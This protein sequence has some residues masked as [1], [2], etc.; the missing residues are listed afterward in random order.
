MDV[1]A[2]LATFVRVADAGSFSAVAR[3]RNTTQP[4]VSRQITALEDHLGARLLQRTTRSLA[5]TPEGRELLE[6]ARRV[7]ADVAEAEA[8]VGSR[9]TSPTGLVRLGATVAMGRMMI[10]P[11]LGTLLT[12][13]PGLEIELS[14]SD[15]IADLVQ[16]GLDFAI[17]V[18]QVTDAGLIARRIGVVETVLVASRD[19]L[20]RHPAPATPAELAGHECLVYLARNAVEWRFERGGGSETVKVTGRFRTDSVDAVRAAVLAS[21]GVGRLPSWFFTRELREGTVQRV[22]PGWRTPRLPIQAVYPSRR[23]LAP[24]TRAVI[25]FLAGEFRLDPLVSDYGLG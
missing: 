11:R 22:L 25:E 24:R 7:L 16:E 23:F 2:A 6:H 10:A 14:L 21:M 5:L 4:G 18:G 19:Y 15:G 9:L 17:R 20:A 13:H 3:E 8:S 1:L 12:R